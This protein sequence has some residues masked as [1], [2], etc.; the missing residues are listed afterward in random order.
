VGV[1]LNSVDPDRIGTWPLGH[2]G[3]SD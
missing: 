1:T 2:P 3:S